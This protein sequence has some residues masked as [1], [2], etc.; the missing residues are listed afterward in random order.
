M[1]GEVSG[2][3]LCLD[4]HILSISG[5][6]H[7]LITG[8]GGYTILRDLFCNKVTCKDCWK[9]DVVLK[10]LRC[11]KALRGFVVNR[12]HSDRTSC[13]IKLPRYLG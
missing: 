6:S 13:K 11:V 1:I 8:I 3:I 9:I 12:H 7:V 10:D 4:G 2:R 5:F